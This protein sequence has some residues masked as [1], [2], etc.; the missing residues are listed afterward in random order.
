MD[1]ELKMRMMLVTARQLTELGD[2]N[3]MNETCLLGK[4]KQRSVT[5]TLLAKIRAASA[6]AGLNAIANDFD[7]LKD[8]ILVLEAPNQ[9]LMSR[10]T[11]VLTY[12]TL[13]PQLQRNAGVPRRSAH[14][15]ADNRFTLC[16]DGSTEFAWGTNH[17]ASK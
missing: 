2:L 5:A 9:S 8:N 11:K 13:P 10:K 15:L 14:D 1:F 16:R 12:H 17:S 6:K 3:E 4:G 7:P